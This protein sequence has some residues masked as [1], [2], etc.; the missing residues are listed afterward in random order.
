MTE[1]LSPACAEKL[2]FL[3]RDFKYFAENFLSIK[4]KSGA[5]HQFK[6]NQ[7]QRYIHDS[8]EKQLKETGKVRAIILKARQMGASTYVGGRFYH[9]TSLNSGKSTYILTHEAEAT[10]KLFAMAKRFYEFVPNELK[11]PL[12]ASNAR[13]L[14]FDG[15]DSQYF[16]GTA[17]HGTGGRGGTIQY[18][19]GS[20][21]AFWPNTDEIVTGVLQSIADIPGT[22]VILE[23]TANGIGNWFYNMCMSALKG[24]SD[25]QLIF[26]P[27]FWM[28]EYEREP[29]SDFSLTDE[30]REIVETYLHKYDKKTQ[31]R[32]M[33][34][35]RY[36]IE[37]EFSGKLWKFRQE[38]PN[39]IQEAFVST[40][41]SL[42]KADLLVKAREC[43][44]K[45]KAAQMVMGVDVAY[46]QDRTVIAFRRGREI[47]AYYSFREVDPMMLAGIVAGLI[48]KHKPVHANFDSAFGYAVVD[49]LKELGYKEAKAVNFGSRAVNSDEFLN[50]RAEMAFEFAEWFKQE[51]INIPDDDD[52]F[53]EIGMIPEL[54][55]RSDG[56]IKLPAKEDII[57]ELG[58][59]CDIFDAVILTF[60]FPVQRLDEI[61]EKR[62]L[63]RQNQQK[64]KSSSVRWRRGISE[65]A[66]GK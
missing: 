1:Q 45:D 29:K 33:A 20:E 38:Y 47:P 31:L 23:S 25:Y 49:R 37:S 15:S 10:K 43:K 8:L 51:N 61:R 14:I 58:H 21:V 11:P 57:K 13:E 59:S 22:E 28:D 7:A 48:D 4:D 26:T 19:H 27:W 46:H 63:A 9:K 41:E 60:A 30:E 50:K 24:D 3:R 44:V 36:R 34:S 64:N 32:K 40:S 52:F 17:G 35:R 54:V 66:K 65:Q 62:L 55:D 42:I 39:S 56:R 6:L 12:R 53:V 5:R 18:F 2:F 16:V